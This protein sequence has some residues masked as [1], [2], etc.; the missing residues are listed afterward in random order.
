[1]IATCRPHFAASVSGSSLYHAPSIIAPDQPH[2]P[3]AIS[4][5]FSFSTRNG[6]RTTTAGHRTDDGVSLRVYHESERPRSGRRI[7]ITRPRAVPEPERGANAGRIRRA[8]LRRA[9]VDDR[10]CAVHAARLLRRG[11][12]LRAGARGSRQLL[13][14]PPRTPRRRLDVRLVH[15]SPHPP[16]RESRGGDGL[17]QFGDAAVELLVCHRHMP[18]EGRRQPRL[19]LAY[20][21]AVWRRVY[22]HHRQGGTTA[23]GEGR[24]GRVQEPPPDAVLWVRDVA[25]FVASSPI[26]T[27]IVAVEY[28]GTPLLDFRHPKRAVYIL[29]SED[30]GLPPGLVTR[31]HHHVSIRSR[32]AGRRV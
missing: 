26:D 11:A 8:T 20:R 21:A 7:M 4:A 18:R 5:E 22:V 27:Q 16:A 29:G 14:P 10:P 1:M 31:A 28:G 2:L 3:P 23:R 12:V 19:A 24:R 15:A 6:C 30:A 9:R 13:P 25:A 17:R 32:R